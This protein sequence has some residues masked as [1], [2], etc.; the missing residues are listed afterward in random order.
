MLNSKIAI[1][2][3]LVVLIG[4]LTLTAQ[5]ARLS[6]PVSGF[7]FDS[8]SHSVRPI[9]GLPGAA[10]LGDPLL[11]GLEWASVAPNGEVALAVK[12]GR[13]FAI[14]G[15]GATAA[16][17]DIEADWPAPERVAWSSD[18]AA[19]A[20]STPEGGLRILRYLLDGPVAASAVDL[21][22]PVAALA[23]EGSGECA[24]AAVTAAGE[25]GLYLACPGA[26]AR[27]LAAIS[28]PAAVVLARGG[29]DLFAADRAGRILEIMD[30]RGA[31]R[32]MPF[33]EMPGSAWDPVGL[34][35][36]A[37]Q[38]LL[39]VAHRAQRRVDAFDLESRTLAAQIGVEGEPALLEP[40]AVRSVFLLRSAGDA[41]EPLLVLDAGREPAVFF[42]PAGRGE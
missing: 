36:S 11:G 6:G 12:D 39:F 35:V 22:G 9:V 19:A 23:L 7:V 14:R 29:R 33:A 5:E 1:I 21:P 34:A 28:E 18:G 8:A 10:Y 15:L 24:A 25:G 38:R 40:L 16:W 26:P 2:G 41:G 17:A 30:F 37:D 42:V 3:L 31:A 4:G 32:V 27:L 20:L 13:W